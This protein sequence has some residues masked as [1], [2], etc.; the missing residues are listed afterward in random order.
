MAVANGEMVLH[1]PARFHQQAQELVNGLLRPRLAGRPVHIAHDAD[2]YSA[3]PRELASA[4]APAPGRRPTWFFLTTPHYHGG[5]MCRKVGCA[6][7]GK[8]YEGY[9][10]LQNYHRYKDVEAGGLYYVRNYVYVDRTR[11]RV[12]GA[13]RPDPEWVMVEYGIVREDCSEQELVL[14]KMYRVNQTMRA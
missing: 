3:T 8:G 11:T 6:A 9:W 2:A 12:P 10:K 14:C 7:G 5:P 4:H 13:P 1:G